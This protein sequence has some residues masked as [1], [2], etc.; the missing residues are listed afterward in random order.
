[1]QVLDSLIDVD[2]AAIF[3]PAACHP[4]TNRPETLRKWSNLMRACCEASPAFTR[5][6]VRCGGAQAAMMFL[7]PLMSFGAPRHI[8]DYLRLKNAW[9][10]VPED[11]AQLAC[12]LVA[13][14]LDAALESVN[15]HLDDAD[16]LKLCEVCDL[17]AL[18]PCE[19]C[20][21]D[22]HKDRC[23]K[24]VA[25]RRELLPYVGSRR[26]LWSHVLQ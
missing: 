8:K 20:E 5:H 2:F 25:V 13:G 6:F 22:L 15:A 14:V 10:A 21:H 1:V 7:W 12:Q 16:L 19:L 26:D 9:M 3:T 18:L 23:C 17:R 24:C 11:W 4:T